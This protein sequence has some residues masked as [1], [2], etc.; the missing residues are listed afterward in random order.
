MNSVRKASNTVL[1]SAFLLGLLAVSTVG[2]AVACKN[3]GISGYNF[4][5]D[6]Q[7]GGGI[8]ADAAGGEPRAPQDKTAAT[9]RERTI[10]GAQMHKLPSAVVLW[11][12]ML[13]WV[14]P[15]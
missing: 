7:G 10:L 13:T 3:D 11:V 4:K 12:R 9:E 5:V 8:A 15:M 2:P 14:R 1:V 6:D